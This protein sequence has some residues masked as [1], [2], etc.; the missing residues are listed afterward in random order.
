M[1]A[2]PT[3]PEI[4]PTLKACGYSPRDVYG[5]TLWTDGKTT[6]TWSDA[7]GA[8]AAELMH[9]RSVASLKPKPFYRTSE[10]WTAAVAVLGLLSTGAGMLSGYLDWLPEE[11]RAVAGTALMGISGLA[12]R[13]YAHARAAEK[14]F[15]TQEQSKALASGPVVGG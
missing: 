3:P 12:A 2:P 9:L 6:G 14:L 4:I 8:V 10:Y 15:A 11:H 1:D 13:W 5:V 7:M